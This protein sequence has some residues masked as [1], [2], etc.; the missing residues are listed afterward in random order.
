MQQRLLNLEDRLEDT[1]G[2]YKGPF[3]PLYLEYKTLSSNEL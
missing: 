3:G 2:K 1:A